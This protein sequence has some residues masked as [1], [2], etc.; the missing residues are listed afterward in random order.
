MD[1]IAAPSYRSVSDNGDYIL[2]VR[3]AIASPEAFARFKQDPRYIYVLEHLS[4]EKGSECL[5]VLYSKYPELLSQHLLT[6]NDQVGSPTKI[7]YPGLGGIE[8]S[9]S[10]LRYLKITGDIEAMYPD[11]PPEGLRVAEIGVGYGGQCLLLDS[12][13]PKARFT[14]FDLPPVLE[15]A[16]K[17]LECHLLRGSYTTQTLNRTGHDEQFDLVISNYAFSE[18]PSVVQRAY[19]EKVLSKSAKG[20]MIMNSGMAGSAFQ[21]DYMALRELEHDLPGATIAPEVPST[22]PGNYVIQW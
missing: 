12:V 11:G 17:Y 8:V 2:A 19:V 20:Y 18:L 6:I 21:G 1:Y 14:L 9:P 4:G 10:T 7:K 22:H 3:E 16:D 15:L 13:L 5:S